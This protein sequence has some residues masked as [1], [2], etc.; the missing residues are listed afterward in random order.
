[1]TRVL[2]GGRLLVHPSAVAW[3]GFLRLTVRCIRAR[4]RTKPRGKQA[5]AQYVATPMIGQSDIPAAGP[6]RGG[7]LRWRVAGAG[8]LTPPAVMR[9]RW[10]RRFAR[11]SAQTLPSIPGRISYWGPARVAGLVFFEPVAR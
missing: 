11:R 1:M 10:S 7:L 4:P 2:G 3:F 6:L 8:S 9:G 5:L